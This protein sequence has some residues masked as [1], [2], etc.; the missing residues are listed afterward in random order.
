MNIWQAILLGLV[1][2][3]A[4]FLPISSSGHLV[5]LQNILHVEG[6]MLLFDTLLHVGSLVAVFV[7]LWP[8][9]RQMLK[10]PLGRI[11]WLLV[12]ATIPA[13]I[14]ALTLESALDALFAGNRLWLGIGFLVTT[15]VLLVAGLWPATHGR[16]GLRAPAE[17][18]N[19]ES[20]TWTQA[21][22]MGCTQAVAIMPGISR[23][24]ST[25]SAGLL[26]GVD[27]EKATRF[28]FLMSI[29]AILG[30]LVFQAKDVVEEGFIVAMGDMSTA[31]VIL[32]MVMAALAGFFALKWMMNLVKKGKLWAFAIYTCV[33]GILTLSGVF[34]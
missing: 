6:E 30:S 26:A 16:H 29:P 4:E 33:I 5:L 21:L 14:A 2:G 22:I 27:R 7:V 34:F 10:K 11:T 23:S 18:P 1:Q 3:L 31:C 9:I 24:G 25:L 20:L 8:D 17:S 12:A 19:L 28:S 13:V 32:G 15:V